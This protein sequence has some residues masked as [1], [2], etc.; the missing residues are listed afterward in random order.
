[1]HFC[2]NF[3]LFGV[4]IYT[5]LEAAVHQRIEF[6]WKQETRSEGQELNPWSFREPAYPLVN[7]PKVLKFEQNVVKLLYLYP[8]NVHFQCAPES[9]LL[10]ENV[11]I[12]HLKNFQSGSVHKSVNIFHNILLYYEYFTTPMRNANASWKTA[13]KE[14]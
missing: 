11:V 10:W 2:T 12:E 13:C 8:E 4:K 7:M 5:V 1:L 14:T 9:R 6:L 3:E